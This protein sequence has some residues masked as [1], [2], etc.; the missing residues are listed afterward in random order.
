EEGTE[1]ETTRIPGWSELLQAYQSNARARGGAQA[2]LP[3][4]IRVR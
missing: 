4:T 1:D 3:Y 2:M